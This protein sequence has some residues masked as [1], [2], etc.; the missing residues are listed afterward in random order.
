[1]FAFFPQLLFIHAFSWCSLFLWWLS[2]KQCT[3][4]PRWARCYRMIADVIAYFRTSCIMV[5]ATAP[6]RCWCYLQQNHCGRPLISLCFIRSHTPALI[7][8]YS[9]AVTGGGSVGECDRFECTLWSYRPT[10]GAYFLLSVKP[11]YGLPN[12]PEWRFNSMIKQCYVII[13][14]LY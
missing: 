6:A 11:L 10:Y 12:H 13:Q 9:L 1:M 4:Y 14:F 3:V 5:A 7:N 2:T 8:A